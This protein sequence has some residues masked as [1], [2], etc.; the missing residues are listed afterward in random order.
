MLIIEV[1]SHS[2][3]PVIEHTFVVALGSAKVESQFINVSLRKW[4]HYNDAFW[5]VELLGKI[6]SST[7]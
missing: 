2:D 1:M 7:L 3:R 5:L 4:I 6:I